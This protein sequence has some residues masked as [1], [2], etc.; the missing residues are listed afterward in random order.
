MILLDFSRQGEVDLL[1][2]MPRSN[3]RNCN[4]VREHVTAGRPVV[5]TKN[6]RGRSAGVDI[7]ALGTDML[8]LLEFLVGKAS[9]R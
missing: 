2:I 9:R 3:L 7:S 6:G 1:K 5:L 8:A 4:A